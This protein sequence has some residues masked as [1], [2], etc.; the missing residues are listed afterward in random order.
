MLH[1]T[2]SNKNNGKDTQDKI[3]KNT[4]NRPNCN[5]N[6]KV[7]ILMP[8]FHKI[9]TVWVDINFHTIV[10]GRIQSECAWRVTPINDYYIKGNSN[11]WNKKINYLPHKH[12]LYDLDLSLIHCI[13][14]LYRI[15]L[16]LVC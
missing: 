14:Y 7:A 9:Y 1:A 11:T 4:K 2:Q 8:H 3:L 6:L 13:Q 12:K 5:F 10:A 16:V 15:S